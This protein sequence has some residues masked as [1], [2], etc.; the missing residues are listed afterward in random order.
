MT[1]G[2]S[3]DEVLEQLRRA[4]SSGDRPPDRLRAAL[5]RTATWDQD[6]G[7]LA[8]LVHDSESAQEF[9]MRDGGASFET[10]RALTF[11][12]SGFTLNLSIETAQRMTTV[13][14]LVSPASAG[15]A[16][17]LKTRS[18]TTIVQWD[19]FGRFEFD[20]T[21]SVFGLRVHIGDRT[22]R[23]GLISL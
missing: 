1:E 12:F 2:L 3:D 5:L 14:A 22:F 7:E 13:Q 20:L 9:S 21:E 19:E 17:I 6:A 11:R 10:V 8:E 16:E 15:N 23:T 4:I 18:E